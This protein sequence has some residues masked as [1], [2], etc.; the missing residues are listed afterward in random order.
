MSPVA[1]KSIQVN[2]AAEESYI[3]CCPIGTWETHA[4]AALSDGLASLT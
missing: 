2:Y 4:S 3:L 1:V